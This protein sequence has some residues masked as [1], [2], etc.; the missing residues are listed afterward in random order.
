MYMYDFIIHLIDLCVC[1]YKDVHIDKEIMLIL[2][3]IFL[4]KNLLKWFLSFSLKKYN[5]NSW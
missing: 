3:T 5:F 1:M 4:K 2:I